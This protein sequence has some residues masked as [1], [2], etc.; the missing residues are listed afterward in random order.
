MSTKNIIIAAYMALASVFMVLY[1]VKPRVKEVEVPVPI[2]SPVEPDS[3]VWTQLTLEQMKSI[4]EKYTPVQAKPK[5]KS[6]AVSSPC[7]AAEETAGLGSPAVEKPSPD[8]S[9]GLKIA[10]SYGTVH[11]PTRYFGVI[12]TKVQARATAPVLDFRAE[13]IFPGGEAAV[14][15]RTCRQWRIE[16]PCPPGHSGS[17]FLG[18]M[19]AGFLVVIGLTFAFGG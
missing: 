12:T 9:L 11:F 3:V 18:G 17:A 15:D 4:V 10:T 1:W 8:T 2:P 13:L 6:S 5:I 16:N 19:S 14:R 7:A